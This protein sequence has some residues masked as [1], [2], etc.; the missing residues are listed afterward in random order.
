MLTENQFNNPADSG[1]LIPFSLNSAGDDVFLVEADAAGNL[2][3]FADRV[4]FSVAPEGMTFG[5]YPDGAGSFDLLRGVTSGGA[6][7]TAIPAY[8]A[9][10]ATQFPPGTASSSM[11]LPADPDSDGLS[12][13]LEF[14]FKLDPLKPDGSPINLQPAAAGTPLQ[15]TFTVRTDVTGLANRIDVSSDLTAWDTTEAA[16]ERLSTVPNADGTATVSVRLR[17]NPPALRKHARIMISL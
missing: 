11:A 10:V 16:V 14:A 17:P 12:N 15:F 3:R 7:T 4:E 9:W 2:L 1:A 8:G 6:N 13:L 5:R